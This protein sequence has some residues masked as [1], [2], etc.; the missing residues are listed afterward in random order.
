MEDQRHPRGNCWA[1]FASYKRISKFK[2]L[3]F[4]K[5]QNPYI[6]SPHK[7]IFWDSGDVDIGVDVDVGHDADVDDEDEDVGSAVAVT[8]M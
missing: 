6:Q 8:K 4:S 7:V 5:L 3:Y 2:T 1:E